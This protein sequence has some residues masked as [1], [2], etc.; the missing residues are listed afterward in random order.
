MW[1]FPRNAT[2]PSYLMKRTVV[3]NLTPDEK[4][5]KKINS[6]HNILKVSEK[7]RKKANEPDIFA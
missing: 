5:K 4:E 3:K 1:I 6:L 7:E 2:I